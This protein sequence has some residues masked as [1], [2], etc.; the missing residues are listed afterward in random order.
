[1]ENTE[2]KELIEEMG[3]ERIKSYIKEYLSCNAPKDKFI[4]YFKKYLDTRAICKDGTKSISLQSFTFFI[5]DDM[6]GSDLDDGKAL[7][8]LDGE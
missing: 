6:Y 7:Y 8:G 2:L 1:M 4:E 5:L 3:E